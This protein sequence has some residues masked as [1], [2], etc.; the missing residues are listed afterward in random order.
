[1]PGT[2]AVRLDP[3]TWNQPRAAAGPTL[4]VLREVVRE[5][6]VRLWSPVQDLLPYLLERWHDLI[7]QW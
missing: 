2:A 1:M 3:E 7:L 4:V 6:R 5:G